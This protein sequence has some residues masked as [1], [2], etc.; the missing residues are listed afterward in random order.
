M[1]KLFELLIK[2]KQQLDDMMDKHI[3]TL[4]QIAGRRAEIEEMLHAMTKSAE[5]ATA[6]QTQQI[7][8]GLNTLAQPSTV[9]SSEPIDPL[10]GTTPKVAQVK[11]YRGKTAN[12]WQA[13]NEAN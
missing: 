5:L 13:K 2:R 6:Q 10:G 11:P 12:V 9:D 1:D 7:L 8:D 4:N 3:A